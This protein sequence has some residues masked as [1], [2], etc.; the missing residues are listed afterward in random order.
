MDDAAGGSAGTRSRQDRHHRSLLARELLGLLRMNT[1]IRVAEVWVPSDDGSLLELQQGLYDAAPAFGASSQAL[2]FGRAEGLPGWAWDE[3]R[4]LLLSQL[5]G[6]CFRRAAAAQAAGLN[7]AIALPI[8]AG[9]RLTSVVVLLCGNGS[10]AQVGAME[11]WHNDPRVTSDLTLADGYFGATAPSLEELSRDTYLPRGTG[12]PGL[13]WQREAAVFIDNIGA[14]HQFL[15]S[16][17]AASA[18]IVRGLAIPCHT[19]RHETW[20]LSLLSSALT[21]IARRVESWI[22]DDSGERLQR[23]FGFCE[24]SGG[25]LPAGEASARPTPTL[26][27][28]GRAWATATAQATRGADPAGEALAAELEAAGLRSVLAIPVVGDDGAT[29]SEVLALYF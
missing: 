7:S 27:A 19:P 13:A 17:T 10:E 24:A 1:F 21:P 25:S 26:G 6:S 3:G 23:A 22:V 12:L 8:F 5:Q 18:G 29:V 11:L 20:V 4:P 28:I 2:Y 9:D 16:Q 14:S 15:R